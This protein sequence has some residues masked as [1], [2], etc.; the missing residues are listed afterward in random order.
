M[1]V[2]RVDAGDEI[3]LQNLNKYTFETYSMKFL[4]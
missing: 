3:A 1:N 4:I 2:A